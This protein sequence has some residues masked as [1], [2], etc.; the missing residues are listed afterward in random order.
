MLQQAN[1]DMNF[2]MQ[3]NTIQQLIHIIKINQRVAISVGRQYLCHLSVIFN[4]LI[5]VYKYYSEQISKAVAQTG[6]D[7]AVKP[8]KTLRK[9]IL[10]LI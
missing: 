2:L 4:D 9:D 6:S 1:Q 3:P 10:S 7:N 8:M 5:M